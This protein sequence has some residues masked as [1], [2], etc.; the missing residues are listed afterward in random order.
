MLYSIHLIDAAG[1]GCYLSVKGR[2]SWKTRRTAR[3]HA[4]GIADCKAQLFGCVVVELENEFG[5]VLETF[6]C[7]EA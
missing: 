7:K 5:E 2:T 3:Y 4:K 6:R 1:Q